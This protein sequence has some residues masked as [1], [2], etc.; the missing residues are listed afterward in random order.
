MSETQPSERSAPQQKPLC[1]SSDVSSPNVFFG[2]KCLI[3]DEQKYLFWQKYFDSH[4]DDC[5]SATRV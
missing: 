4:F 3:L 5:C 1:V 2:E